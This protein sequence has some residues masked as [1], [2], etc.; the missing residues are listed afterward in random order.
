MGWALRHQGPGSDR[1]VPHGPRT[2][3]SQIPEGPP[4][5]P[6]ERAAWETLPNP[7]RSS[8]GPGAS[9]GQP[10]GALKPNLQ[11]GHKETWTKLS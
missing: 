11:S 10:Q 6:E 8:L 4:C 3:G 5:T 1:A 7:S 2:G 9:T